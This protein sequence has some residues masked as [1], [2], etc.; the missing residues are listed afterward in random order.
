MRDDDQQWLTVAGLVGATAG[1]V[2]KTLQ[3][4]WRDRHR[5][6]ISERD[7]WARLQA[8]DRRIDSLSAQLATSKEE[9]SSLRLKV[10]HLEAENRQLRAAM[11]GLQDRYD[12]LSRDYEEVRRNGKATQD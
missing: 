1:V 12:A 8:M 9:S 10:A 11:A 7:L 2:G 3:G 6:E 4:W 5:R